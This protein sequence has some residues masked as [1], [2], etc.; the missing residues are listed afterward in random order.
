MTETA[1]LVEMT[2]EPSKDRVTMSSMSKKTGATPP[3]DGAASAVRE[4]ARAGDPERATSPER[5]ERRTFTVEYN[6]WTETSLALELAAG[7]A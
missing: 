1:P 2:V 6:R 4:A 5:P 3:R 7:A